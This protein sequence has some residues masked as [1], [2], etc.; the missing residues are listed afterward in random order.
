[1]PTLINQ[2]AIKVTSAL[3]ERYM[4]DIITIIKRKDVENK[5]QE[6]NNLHPDLHFTMEREQEGKIPFLDMILIHESGSLSSSWY[7]KPTD[8]GLMMNYYALGPERYKKSIVVGMIHRIYRACSS[9]SNI[10]TSLQKAII[11]LMKNQYPP[12]FFEPIIYE[13]LSHI[14]APEAKED[15]KDDEE[16]KNP[17]LFFMQYRGRCSDEFSKSL[18]RLLCNKESAFQLPTRVIFTLNKLKTA[19]PPLKEPVS[20]LLK[21]GVVYHLT[22]PSCKA[23][24]VG[25]TIRHLMHRFREHRVNTGPLRKHLET[26]NTDLEEDD[27]KVLTTSSNQEKLLILEALFIRELKPTINTKE[28]FKSKKLRIKF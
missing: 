7:S 4:D 3:Y 22:C 10:D 2:D 6:I 11:L 5:L 23:S 26:C 12:S 21:S 9:Y 16:D 1:M 18:R 17:F 28:E 8:T 27:V 14:I 13:T 15:K 24:Y 25:E 20:K 19:L